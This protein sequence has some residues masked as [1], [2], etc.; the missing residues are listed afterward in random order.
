VGYTVEDSFAVCD[1]T[2]RKKM[3]PVW[4]GKNL[5]LLWDTTEEN[6]SNIL[7]LHWMKT[8]FVVSHGRKKSLPLFSKME[9]TSFI[10][11]HTR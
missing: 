11:S 1:T 8:S 2:G 6:L 5:L 3:V 10:V 4:D 7:K 9:K